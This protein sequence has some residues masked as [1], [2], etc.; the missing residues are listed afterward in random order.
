VD[1]AELFRTLTLW[2]AA[3]IF[4]QTASGESNAFVTAAGIVALA[5]TWLLPIYLVAGVIADR[6]AE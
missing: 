1:R 3:M 2:F 5:L 6:R 4:V